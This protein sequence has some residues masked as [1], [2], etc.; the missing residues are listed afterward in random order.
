[1]FC[2]NKGVYE[3]KGRKQSARANWQLNNRCKERLESGCVG[4][5]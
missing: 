5:G 3:E 2:I 4:E 1:M